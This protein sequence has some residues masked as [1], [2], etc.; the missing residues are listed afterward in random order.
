MTV[1]FMILVNTPGSWS[2]IYPP[3]DHANWHGCSPTDLVFPFFLFALGNALAFVMPR[4]IQQGSKAFWAKTTKRALL[5]FTIGLLLNWFPFV[6]YNTAGEL[7][8]KPFLDL[9]LL[10]VLQRIALCYFFASIIAY[11][12][13]PAASFLAALALLLIYWVLCVSLGA[14]GDPFSINGWFGTRID[15]LLL[16]ETH[17]YH[18]EGRAFDPEGIASTLPAIAQVLIG[19]VTGDY[20]IKK[21]AV[22]ENTVTDNRYYPLVAN[23][24]VISLMLLF[25]GLCWNSLFPINKKIWTSSYVVYTSGMAIIILALCIYALEIKQWR[26][27]WAPFFD[28]FGKNPLFIFVLSGV[29]ARLYGLVRWED[30]IKDGKPVFKGLGGYMYDHIFVPLF[31]AMNGSLFY[32]IFHVLIF[33]LIALWLDKKKIYIKV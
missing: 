29:W 32:A 15:L 25:T 24:L 10:G 27:G 22:A 19:Y 31:G 18:G 14:P 3:L 28:S 20:I 9:R 4:S 6:K 21:V 13:K 8:A 26:K 17:M 2:H 5:I 16:G 1:A 33:W 30:G 12:L 23:L 7:V 11:Y